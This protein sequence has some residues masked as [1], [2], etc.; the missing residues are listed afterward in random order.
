LD[1]SA[2]QQHLDIDRAHFWRAAKR[3]LLRDLLAD[4]APPERKLRLLDIGGASSLYPAV[5]A[6]WGS[7]TVVEPDRE[8]VET[9]RAVLGTDIRQGSLPDALG[10]EGPFDVISMLDVLEHIED[11]RRALEVVR[12]LL[13]PGGRLI[14]TVPALPALYSD[15]DRALHHFR[16]YTRRSLNEAIEG[17]GLRAQRMSYWTSL[18]LPLVAAQRMV[19]KTR[20]ALRPNPNPEYSVELPGKTLNWI[21]GAAMTMERHLL[22]F[23]RMPLGSSLF[24]VVEKE[25][26]LG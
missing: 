11:D 2:Y 18:L 20:S 19:S 26:G 6:E 4:V 3:E 10:V 7:V 15:H 21:L 22:R 13:A 25:I 1:R 5:L 17:S 23:T 8:C 12:G 16:R 9:A 14:I 24:A